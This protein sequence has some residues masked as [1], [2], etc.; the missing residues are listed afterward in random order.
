MLKY[1][2][3]NP[4]EALEKMIEAV[5][6]TLPVRDI[7]GNNLMTESNKDL[8]KMMREE[9]ANLRKDPDKL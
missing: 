6:K 3:D 1:A 7:S 5:Q 9:R 8:E 4:L 2:Q